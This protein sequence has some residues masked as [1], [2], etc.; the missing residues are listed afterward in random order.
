MPSIG[1][2]LKKLATPGRAKTNVWFFKTGKGQDGEGDSFLGVSVPATRRVAKKFTHLPLEELSTSLESKFHEHRLCA[3]LVLVEKFKKADEKERK[4][5]FDFYLSKTKFVNNWDLVDLSADKIVGEY[6]FD[7]EKK[8]LYALAK[9]D[10]LWERRI[11][12]VSTFA[13]IRRGELKDTFKISRILLGDS[14]DLIYK[15]CGWMLREAGKRDKNAL[16]QFLEAHKSKMPR[17]MLRY[18]IEKFS[19][20]ER[21]HFMAK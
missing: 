2:E 17:T 19:P 5:I 14:H 4:E 16:V 1:N 21:A 18:A 20:Q 10:S 13:L 6:L 3:L 11:A 7:K 9:S 12:I 8:S 15:A